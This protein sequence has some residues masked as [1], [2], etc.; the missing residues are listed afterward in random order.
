MNPVN[1]MKVNKA[2]K[3]VTT[4]IESI[5]IEIFEYETLIDEAPEIT[6]DVIEA[7]QLLDELYEQ[8][9]KEVKRKEIYRVVLQTCR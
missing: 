4:D 7:V 8:Y 3:K 1:Y 2:I 9:D 5:A 6:N